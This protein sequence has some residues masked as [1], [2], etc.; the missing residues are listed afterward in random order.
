MNNAPN[1]RK[2][3]NLD[4]SVKDISVLKGVLKPRNTFKNMA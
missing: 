1:C 4:N 2:I 3:S